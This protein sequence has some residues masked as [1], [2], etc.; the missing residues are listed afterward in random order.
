MIEVDI[1]NILIYVNIKHALANYFTHC[2]GNEVS[3]KKLQKI[4]KSLEDRT[5]VRLLLP[6]DPAENINGTSFNLFP[7]NKDTCSFSRGDEIK[8]GDLKTLELK[9]NWGIS[10]PDTK[11]DYQKIVKRKRK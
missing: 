10:D 2:P 11:R 4:S 5:N 9:Y 3:F 1:K 7:Y 6:R 8:F